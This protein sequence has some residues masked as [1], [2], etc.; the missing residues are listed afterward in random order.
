[1]STM[2]STRPR[3]TTRIE[4]DLT[5]ASLQALF[6]NE[7]PAIRIKHFATA[8]ECRQFVAA[9]DRVGL[10]RQYNVP[11]LKNPPRYIGLT[12]FDYRKRSR[13]EYF[14]AVPGAIGERARFLALSPFDPIARMIE[15]LQALPPSQHVGIALEPGHG[16]YYAGVIR[17]T[18]GGGTLHADFTRFSAPTYWVSGNDAQVAWNFFVAEPQTGGV[19]TLHNAPFDPPVVAGQYVEIEPYDRRLVEGAETHRYKPEEGDLI[20]F[21]SRNPH[22]WTAKA[23]TDASRRLSIGT[24]IGRRPDGDLVLWS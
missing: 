10:N 16:P 18:S 4:P 7:I 23:E 11:K 6:A 24:F 17:D 13:E 19:T 1:M 3:W 2:T 22:E 20:M 8:A 12:Q 9:L 15:R 21:N 14:A 5:A